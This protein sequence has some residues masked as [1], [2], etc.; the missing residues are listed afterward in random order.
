MTLQWSLGPLHGRA[1]VSQWVVPHCVASLAARGLP[2]AWPT[3]RCSPWVGFQAHQEKEDL[4]GAAWQTDRGSDADGAFGIAADG[5][6]PR[7]VMAERLSTLA[8]PGLRRADVGSFDA[9][10]VHTC[11]G[12]RV[13]STSSSELQ[14]AGAAVMEEGTKCEES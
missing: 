5:V 14:V 8:E 12:T 1:W 6:V 9:T 10:E 11:K 3:P 13:A 7:T 2:W 4:A